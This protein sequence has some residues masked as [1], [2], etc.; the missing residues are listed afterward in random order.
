[1][2]N[3][4]KQYLLALMISDIDDKR[5]CLR[6][7]EDEF[8]EAKG[9]GSHAEA[10]DIAAVINRMKKALKAAEAAMEDLIG[11]ETDEIIKKGE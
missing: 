9:A 10:G 2:T 8:R 7:L 5:A 6:V 4:S 3:N 11:V 1:M